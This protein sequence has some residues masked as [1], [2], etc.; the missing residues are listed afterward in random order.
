MYA[1][2]YYTLQSGPE[3][4]HTTGGGQ[5]LYID[6]RALPLGY[7][8]GNGTINYR[9]MEP[10]ESGCM[11]LYYHMY[12]AYYGTN[13][14][15]TGRCLLTLT[16]ESSEG[17]PTELIAM[18]GSKEPAWLKLTVQVPP[19]TVLVRGYIASCNVCISAFN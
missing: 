4:D 17:T 14:D 12:D 13:I 16:A 10:V 2:Y 15:R 7:G 8:V 9:F 19:Q 5:Y 1:V 3:R 18:K 11:S 6:V